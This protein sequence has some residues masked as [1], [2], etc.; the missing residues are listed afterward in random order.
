MF[1]K[2]L[3]QQFIC[4]E[5]LITKHFASRMSMHM[6]RW[7]GASTE[8]AKV[9]LYMSNEIGNVSPHMHYIHEVQILLVPFCLINLINTLI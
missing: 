7:E 4:P 8:G 1:Q 2:E 3:M 5:T 9:L 6:S